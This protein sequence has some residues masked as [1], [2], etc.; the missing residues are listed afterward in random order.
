MSAAQKVLDINGVKDAAVRRK[1]ARLMAEHREWT[2]S[3][4]EQ[5]ATVE[6]AKKAIMKQAVPLL[7]KLKADKLVG[8]GWQTIRLEGRK[9]IKAELLVARGVDP[10]DIEAATV[11]GKPSWSV[12]KR[13]AAEDEG[14]EG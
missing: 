2:D 5:V 10:D 9:S 11:T 12:R 13:G 8:E 3:I 6:A 1:L 14:D 7:E 4:A